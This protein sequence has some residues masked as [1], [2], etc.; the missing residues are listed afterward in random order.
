MAAFE[1]DRLVGIATAAFDGLSAC[2]MEFCLELRYQGRDLK[3]GN[4]SIVEKDLTGVGKKM[5]RTLIRELIKMGATF[6]E[7]NIVENREEEFYESIGFRR[8]VGVLPYYMDRR[9]Y[10][11]NPKRIAQTRKVREGTH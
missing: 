5:G 6:I 10:T 11:L 9:P 2:V 7:A 8:N 4:G 3:E 1:N